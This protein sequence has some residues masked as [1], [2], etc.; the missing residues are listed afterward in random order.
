MIYEGTRI[1]NAT[2]MGWSD[3]EFSGDFLWRSEAVRDTMFDTMYDTTRVGSERVW[4]CVESLIR[5][6]GCFGSW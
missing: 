4:M 2:G 3:L 1:S 6:F 5:G